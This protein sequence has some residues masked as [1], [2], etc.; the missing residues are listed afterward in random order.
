MTQGTE[1]LSDDEMNRL[2][3][4]LMDRID[5]DEDTSEKNE[6]VLDVSELDGFLTAVVSGPNAIP[7]TE[8]LPALWGD[9][10]PKWKSDPEFMDVVSIIIRHM[11]AIAECLMESPQN[12]EPLFLENTVGE[13]TYDI[14]D[15]WCHGYTMGIA[16]DAEAW[17]D[18]GTEMTGLI[19]PILSFGHGVMDDALEKMSDDE[20]VDMQQLIAPNARAIHAYWLARRFES[21]GTATPVLIPMGRTA[22][23]SAPRVGRNDPCPCGSGKKFK[24]CCLH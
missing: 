19:S 15:E 11:N 8:W 10:P 20:I 24:K 12:Y 4:F 18:S 7:P 13:K 6:G 9:Y 1:E 3:E 14:V 23:A 2:G 17:M 21:D 22:P 16:L 5:D